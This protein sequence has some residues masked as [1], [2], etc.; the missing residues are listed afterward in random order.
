MS[1]STSTPGSSQNTARLTMV[2]LTLLPPIYFWLTSTMSTVDDLPLLSPSSLSELI[3]LLKPMSSAY[4]AAA[5][6]LTEVQVAPSTLTPSH[7]SSLTS[8][9]EYFF[10]DIKS[11]IFSSTISRNWNRIE[12]ASDSF[13][14]PK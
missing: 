10:A 6:F 13:F 2:E 12:Y 7:L 4:R 9:G 14:E 3:L 11:V 1:F 8:N 5:K